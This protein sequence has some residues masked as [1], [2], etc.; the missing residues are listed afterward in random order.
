MANKEGFNIPISMMVGK[1]KLINLKS[2]KDEGLYFCDFTIAE[3]EV[4]EV[5]FEK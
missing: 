2:E 1:N 3:L 5:I 4:W